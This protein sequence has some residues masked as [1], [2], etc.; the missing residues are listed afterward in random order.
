[1]S[2][3]NLPASSA[4]T[5]PRDR[6]A[7]IDVLRGV[8]VLGILAI[9]IWF[10]AFPFDIASKP[11]LLSE[12]FGADVAAWW[13]GWLGIEGSQRAIFT[14]L[15]GASV[16]L[17][18]E[19]LSSDERASML[20]RIYYR[21]TVLLILFGLI[22]GYILLWNGDILFFYG[23]MGL[24]LFFVRKWRPRSLITAGV[25]I[26]VLL[27]ALNF[28]MHFMTQAFAPIAEVAQEK[29]ARGES[30]S[31]QE[32]A[33]VD[34]IAELPLAISS[35]EELQ[36]E[37][38][39]RRAGYASAF[40]PNVYTTTE[41]YIIYG[42]FSLFWESLAYM[43]IGMAFF[44]LKLFDASRATGLYVGLLIGGF[45]IGL[46]VNAWEQLQSIEQNYRTTF[47]VWSYDIGRMATALGY[48]GLVMLICK[49]A[50]LPRVR[51]TLA[52]VGKMAL[53]N[54]IAQSIV[55]NIV[56]IG[57]G[58]FGQLRFHE[59]YYV[60]FAMWAA[61]LII[62]PIWLRNFSYGPLEWLWRRLTYGQPV[63][64]RIT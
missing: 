32:Q 53:S 33:A 4:A 16:L 28:W 42:L 13:I 26:I 6:I 14:M 62:S 34:F 12:Y 10:F 43:M 23:V 2:E 50:W 9:N 7:S 54:Y 35:P 40:L 46:S 22:N 39:A 44:R 11:I 59:I 20:T 1:M 45:A 41:A 57:F 60:V 15:F 31:G 18:T 8:A 51:N 29:L 19:R 64:M 36:E 56:F 21:R 3:T 5:D 55:C 61:L 47:A 63:R 58:L 30:L 37:I 49:M 25:I 52:A 38:D 24:L 48:V 27:G 17:F